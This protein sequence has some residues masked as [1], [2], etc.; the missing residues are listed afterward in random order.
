MKASDVKIAKREILHQGFCHLE[1]YTM[2]HRRFDGAW[3]PLYERELI[4]KP[5]V[6]AALP[7]DS[8]TDQVVLIEQFRVGALEYNESAWLMEVV[9][10]IMDKEHENSLEDLIYREMLEET[11][12]QIE[13]LL[14]IYDYLVTPGCSTEKVKLFCAKV[15]ATKASEYCGLAEEHEDIRVHVFSSQEAF[16][17]VRSGKINNSAAI[18]ALQWLELNKQEVLAKF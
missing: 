5:R 9:A 1:R 2:Q 14:P 11:C 7:Y 13:K 6:A 12:L 18:I 15:D 16:A 4:L 10:G 17:L 3:M 8:R